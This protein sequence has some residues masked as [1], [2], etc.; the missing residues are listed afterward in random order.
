MAMIA[1]TFKAP[2]YVR[3]GNGEEVQVGT[4]EVPIEFTSAPASPPPV[5][6]LPKMRRGH[7]DL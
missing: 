2:V 1:G 4:I 5:P 3:I 6:P 7:Q